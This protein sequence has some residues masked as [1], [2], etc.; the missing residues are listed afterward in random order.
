MFKLLILAFTQEFATI[1]Y[2]FDLQFAIHQ[3]EIRFRLI[4]RNFP[5][6]GSLK[7]VQICPFIMLFKIRYMLIFQEWGG[8]CPPFVHSRGRG[9]KLVRF[10]STQLLNDPLELNYEDDVFKFLWPPQIMLTLTTHA[11]LI[12]KGSL[13]SKKVLLW[14]KSPKKMCQITLLSNIRLRRRCSG[15]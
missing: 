3:K 9:S 4:H 11:I 7:C 12:S 8:L 6:L 14:L 5:G 15:Q 10:W 2:K 13:I 1:H